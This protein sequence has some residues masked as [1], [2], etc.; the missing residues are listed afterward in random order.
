MQIYATRK[1]LVGKW[2][3]RLCLTLLRDGA[4]TAKQLAVRMGYTP[5]FA[6]KRG[7]QALYQMLHR[8]NRE[9]ITLSTAWGFH[10]LSSEGKA[11]AHQLHEELHP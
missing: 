7:Q 4:C 1:I 2:K 8:F 5:W 3:A 9:G 6:H 10:A 11:Y